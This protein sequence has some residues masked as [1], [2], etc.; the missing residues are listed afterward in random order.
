MENGK[1]IEY[2]LFIWKSAKAK[3]E[4]NITFFHMTDPKRKLIKKKPIMYIF[5]M[6]SSSF[7]FDLDE[8]LIV[9]FW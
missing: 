6:C 1:S 2:V 5:G 3:M 4:M 7:S 8:N 9:S